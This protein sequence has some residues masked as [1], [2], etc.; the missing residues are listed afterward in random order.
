MSNLNGRKVK[1]LRTHATIHLEGVGQLTGAITADSKGTL[2]TLEMV[3]VD[4]GVHIKF[5][6]SE[7]FI[8]DG[9][10]ISLALMPEVVVLAK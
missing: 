10:I 3:K 5:K 4:G 1:V 9:N 8:P 7:G 6:T 2:G